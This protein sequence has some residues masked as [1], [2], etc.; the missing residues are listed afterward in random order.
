LVIKAFK[1]YEEENRVASDEE[2]NSFWIIAVNKEDLELVNHNYNEL[3]QLK[4]CYVFFPIW[5]VSESSDKVIAVHENMH[6]CVEKSKKC[7]LD[8]W[9]KL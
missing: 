1:R 5:L 2:R 4:R 7:A 6:K 3:S 9:R 8:F